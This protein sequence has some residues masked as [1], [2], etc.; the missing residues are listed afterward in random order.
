LTTDGESHGFTLEVAA[1]GKISYRVTESGGVDT[2]AAGADTLDPLSNGADPAGDLS[3][4]ADNKVVNGADVDAEG[5]EAAEVDDLTAAEAC[6]DGAYRMAGHKEYGIYAWYIGDGGMPGG[7]SRNDAKRAFHDAIASITNSRN[8]CGYSDT[9]DARMRFVSETSREAGIN[10]RSQCLDSDGLSV[11]DAG[12]LKGDVVAMTC[13]WAWT[14]P[15]VKD[16][17]READVR[18]NTRDYDFTN[19]PTSRCSNKYDIR[20]IGTHEAGHVFGLGHVGPRHE[21]LTMFMNAF[22]CKK[23]GRTLGKGDVIALRSLY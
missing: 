5:A 23:T 22:T 10:S 20:S 4:G 19:R 16:D 13:S 3:P 7:L 17:L 14:R 8:N 21:N 15:G 9:V 1:D 11:W 6:R 2:P 12:D 18:F